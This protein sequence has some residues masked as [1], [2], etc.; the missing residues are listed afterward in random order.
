MQIYFIA[1]TFMES[2]YILRI[3]S[4]NVKNTKNMQISYGNLMVI[5]WVSYGKRWY[6]IANRILFDVT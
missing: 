3:Y 4:K 6:L 1:N 5:L 2:I